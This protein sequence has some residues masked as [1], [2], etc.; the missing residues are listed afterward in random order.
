VRPMAPSLA[1]RLAGK[2]KHNSRDTVA[3]SFEQVLVF[4][5]HLLC[6]YASRSVIAL[7]IDASTSTIGQ[8]YF[9]MPKQKNAKGICTTYAYLLNAAIAC[10][11]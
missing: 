10:F 7:R 5:E 2:Q 8:R 6:V 1:P 3:R 11:L 4:A 9:D